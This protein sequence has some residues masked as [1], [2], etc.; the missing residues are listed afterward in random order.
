LL[1]VRV[2]MASSAGKLG[3]QRGDLRF[4]RGAFAFQRQLLPLGFF[5]QVTRSAR[6]RRFLLPRA[7][8]R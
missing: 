2:M 5:V 8:I 6:S 7:P 3:A 4:E 1:K